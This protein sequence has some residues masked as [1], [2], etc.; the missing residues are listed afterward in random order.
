[1]TELE[2]NLRKA[3]RA[4]ASEITPPPPPLELR[5]LATLDPAA[6]G[7]SGRFRAPL[8][9]RRLVP[10]A[11]AVAVIAVAAGALAVGGALPAR[12]P[13]PAAP[14]QTSVPPYYVAL[15][16]NGLLRLGAFPK[17]VATVRETG[18]GAVIARISPP[19]PY[20]SF[21]AVSGAADDRT[22]MLEARGNPIPASGVVPERF[23]L[24]RITPS[25]TSAAR[26]ATLTALPAIDISGGYELRAMALS[27]DGSSLAAILGQGIQDYLHVYNLTTGTT[28]TWVR[29]PCS[30]CG[31]SQD[32]LGG[33][34]GPG[35]PAA[36]AASLSWTA[37]GNSL[38]LVPGGGFDQ[39]RLLDLGTP[40]DNVQP[41]SRPFAIHGVPV[42]HWSEAYMTPDAKT[43]FISYNES[44]GMTY[45]NGLLRYSAR[46][47]K[48]TRIN[49]TTQSFEG[50]LTGYGSDTVL[51]ATYDGSEL[52]VTGARRA[53][54][55]AAKQFP[56][57]VVPD[58][59]AGIYRGGRYSPIPWPANVID[60][61]W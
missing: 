16:N 56:F 39:L 2:N 57:V 29:K 28:R 45:W 10:L 3:L 19:G 17:A 41:N 30:G 26:R 38:A 7:G 4:K 15:V 53:P 44:R 23:Y 5:P 36:A 9:Q 49:K 18:T 55:L 40:G 6:R 42:S 48:L 59:T 50:H 46:T 22:F 24:L 20:V 1:M 21:D 33:P 52:V 47:G 11:A 54:V 58:R 13:P 25:A 32:E 8:Q 12:R 35:Y 34:A 51:W 43:V 31:H 27:P 61:A 14:I 60:A 37:D